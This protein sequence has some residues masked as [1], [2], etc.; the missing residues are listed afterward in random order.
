L[1]EELGYSQK[2]VPMLLANML[3]KWSNKA[4]AICLKRQSMSMDIFL[5]A[6][7]D[8]GLIELIYVITH[9]L[10]ADILTEPL[11]V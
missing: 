9:K 7:I 4:L 3:C 8:E 2:K 6:L 5:K 1:L 11:N 10:V